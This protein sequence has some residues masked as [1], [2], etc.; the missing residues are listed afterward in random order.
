MYSS[1]LGMVMTASVLVTMVCGCA[2]L[3][4]PSDEDLISGTIDEMT[5]AMQA[6]DVDQIMAGYSEDFEGER[7]G[8]EELRQMMEY[9]I[10]EGYLDSIEIDTENAVAAVDGATAT[11]GPVDLSGEFGSMTFEYVLRKEADGVWRIMES[12]SDQ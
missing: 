2:M 1:K 8:K 12:N 4:G 9:I 5:T 7:G 6:H 11:Y 10:D 3:G